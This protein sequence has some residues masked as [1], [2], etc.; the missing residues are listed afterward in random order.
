MDHFA[1]NEIY[2]YTGSLTTPPCTEGVAWYISSKP[3]PLSVQSYNALKKVIKF[4]SRYTQNSPGKGNLLEVEADELLSTV[5]RPK[6]DGF[7]KDFDLEAVLHVQG[8]E[9]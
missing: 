5:Q 8:L 6:S 1:A 7:N 4:N 9:M 3:L 2:H